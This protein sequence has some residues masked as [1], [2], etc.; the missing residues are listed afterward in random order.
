MATEVEAVSLASIPFSRA[1]PDADAHDNLLLFVKMGAGTVVHAALEHLGLRP[2]VG[3][4]PE[5]PHALYAPRDGSAAVAVDIIRGRLATPNPAGFHP[6]LFSVLLAEALSVRNVPILKTLLDVGTTEPLSPLLLCALVEFP[7]ASAE[8]AQLTSRP[9]DAN[10]RFG[11]PVCVFSALVRL[12]LALAHADAG[13]KQSPRSKFTLAGLVALVDCPKLFLEWD[14]LK[15]VS[16]PMVL[17]EFHKVLAGDPV[18]SIT[19]CNFVP[20]YEEWVKSLDKETPKYAEAVEGFR[21]IASM[22]G[23]KERGGK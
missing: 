3:L 6:Y 5:W 18:S 10:T 12:A 4:A 11:G 7:W 21:A 9:S 17:P 15:T 2:A 13:Q 22:L 14:R 20:R 1:H 8:A 23:V 16:E 19:R